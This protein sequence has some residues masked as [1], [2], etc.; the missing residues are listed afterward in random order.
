MTQLSSQ[1]AQVP[2]PAVGCDCKVCPFK[3]SQEATEPMC[4]RCNTDC[5][6]WMCPLSL[7]R[8]AGVCAMA[9]V[10]SS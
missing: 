2:A 3:D 10:L 6:Y 7:R 1:D 5:V 9:S 4:S 8:P